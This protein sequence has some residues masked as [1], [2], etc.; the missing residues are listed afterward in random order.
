MPESTDLK[1][2]IEACWKVFWNED[3]LASSVP[4]A[5]VVPDVEL[6]PVDGG[7]ELDE[8]H[9]ATDRAI[10]TTAPPIAVACFLPRSCICISLLV[11][12]M[13]SRRDEQH[14]QPVSGPGSPSTVLLLAVSARKF[15]VE[16]R[17]L[18]G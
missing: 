13:V 9:A 17:S 2:E 18:K 11:G 6:L 12:F 7:E 16:S 14:G 3:P 4:L 15:K 8:E 5:E 1:A 10:T